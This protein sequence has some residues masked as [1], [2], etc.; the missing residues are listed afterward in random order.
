MFAAASLS[1]LLLTAAPA[2]QRAAELDA[3]TAPPAGEVERLALDPFYERYC[4]ASGIPVVASAKVSPYALLEAR[5]LIDHMLE[6]RDDIR[7]KLIKNKVRFAIMAVTEMTT[8]V[9]EHATL[10]PG[11]SVL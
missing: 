3:V 10:E 6:G 11:P 5:H 8:A 2:S 1:A 7:T 9:P 4:S